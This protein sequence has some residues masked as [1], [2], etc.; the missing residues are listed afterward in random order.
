M[1]FALRDD[2]QPTSPGWSGQLRPVSLQR[3]RAV[4]WT[5]QWDCDAS[6][7]WLCPQFPGGPGPE[8]SCDRQTLLP[9]WLGPDHGPAARGLGR[10]AEPRRPGCHFK[11]GAMRRELECPL[12]LEPHVGRLCSLPG[13][14]GVEGGP[15]DREMQGAGDGLSWKGHVRSACEVP[16]SY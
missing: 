16:W 11:G 1:T 15:G 3:G 14:C 4:P 9:A 5:I 2:A 6:V 7:P 13:C 8:D 12:G 10:S